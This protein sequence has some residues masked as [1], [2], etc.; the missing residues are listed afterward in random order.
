MTMQIKMLK[1]VWV[2]GKAQLMNEVVEVEKKWAMYLIENNEA[3]EYQA[4]K[5]KK[6]C[7]K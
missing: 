5:L 6:A 2:D 3:Q 1:S 7:V 4:K